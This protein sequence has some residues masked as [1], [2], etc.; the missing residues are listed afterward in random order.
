MVTPPIAKCPMSSRSADLLKLADQPLDVRLLRLG[1]PGM[2]AAESGKRERDRVG[3][4][5]L[6]AKVVQRATGLGDSVN[7]EEGMGQVLYRR[8]AGS[9]GTVTE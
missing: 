7:E 1:E 4:T 5:K 2:R 3:S 9:S 8:R 6:S